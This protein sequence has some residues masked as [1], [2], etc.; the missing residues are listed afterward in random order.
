MVG[1]QSL[2]KYKGDRG[3]LKWP[4]LFDFMCLSPNSH[5]RQDAAILPR[6]L[7]HKNGWNGRDRFIHCQRSRFVNKMMLDASSSDS[8]VV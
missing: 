5:Q 2:R 1:T 3:G 6:L 7:L 8:M 4:G